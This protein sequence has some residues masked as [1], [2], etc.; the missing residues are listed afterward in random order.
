MSV[1]LVTAGALHLSRRAES[2]FPVPDALI[3]GLWR[4][5]TAATRHRT[6]PS[7]NPVAEAAEVRVLARRVSDSQP[8]FASD[9]LAAADRHERQFGVDR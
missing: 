2:A 5:L 4:R 7:R 1:P 8:G 6:L 9:L 3:R